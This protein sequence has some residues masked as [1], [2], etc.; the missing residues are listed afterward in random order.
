MP[1]I[2]LDARLTYYRQGGIPQYTYHLIRELAELDT[3]NHYAILHSRKDRRDLTAAPNQRR[4][5]CW[6]PAHNRFERLALGI[7]LAPLRLDL[8]HSPDF[9]P[10]HGRGYCKVITIHDLAFLLYPDILTADSRRYYTDQIHDAAR[11]ANHIIVV[12]EATRRDVLDMLDVPSEKIAVIPE[13]ADER[14]RPQPPDDIERVR[15]MYNLPPEYIL[16][17]GTY[18]P[19]KNLGGLLR[20]YEQLCAELPGAPLLVIA[21]ARGWLYEKAFKL[22]GELKLDTKVTWLDNLRDVDLPGLYSG[23]QLL[24]LPSFY[25]GFGLPALE[26]MA[27]GTPVVSSDRGSL[28]EVVG[29]AAMQVNP[30]NPAD[31]AAGLHRV[32]TNTDLASRLRRRGLERAR[33]FSWREAARRT[34]AV[35]HHVLALHSAP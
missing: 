12:S 17:V 29:D 33:L 16:F 9:I 22:V 31:I 2:G 28:P 4:V 10:P 25:E 21:G 1:A 27:C 35:Y 26:A 34:L 20:A 7:E 15:Q 3:D 19:R 32:L 11:C 13:A 8:L 14:Y 6:T 24:C 5:A 23:A 30:D 18:E